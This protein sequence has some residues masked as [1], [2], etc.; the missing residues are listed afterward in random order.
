VKPAWRKGLKVAAGVAVCLLALRWAPHEPLSERFG[1]S[2][3]VRAQ[4]GELLRL[5]LAPDQQY[6]LWV[7]LDRMSPVLLDS[8]RLYEDRWF[9]W[10]PGVNPAALVRSAWST[11][12]GGRRQGGSTRR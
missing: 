9:G 2:V 3:A 7:P 1:G 6:R 12:T 5:T 10:H 4:G 8:V 11:F